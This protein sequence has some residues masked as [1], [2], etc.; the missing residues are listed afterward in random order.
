MDDDY[1]DEINEDAQRIFAKINQQTHDLMLLGSEIQRVEFFDA[2][3]KLMTEKEFEGDTTAVEVLSW[4]YER[5][6]EEA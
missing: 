3:R 6:G 2:F 5:L 1:I 4:A